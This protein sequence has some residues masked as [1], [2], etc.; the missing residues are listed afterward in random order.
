MAHRQSGRTAL[1]VITCVCVLTTLSMFLT[2]AFGNRA[3][4][5]TSWGV[6]VLEA[7][8]VGMFWAAACY[9]LVRWFRQAVDRQENRRE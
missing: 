6:A 8:L 2:S 5:E 4:D 9:F 7:L 1:V 3:H